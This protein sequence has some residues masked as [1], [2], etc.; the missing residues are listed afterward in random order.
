MKNPRTA[1]IP[2]L[3]YLTELQINYHIRLGNKP[4]Y[5]WEMR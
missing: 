4:L 1:T 5:Y 3:L 2:L